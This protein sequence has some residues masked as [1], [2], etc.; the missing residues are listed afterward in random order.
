MALTDAQLADA[1]RYMGYG[2]DSTT[3]L[4]ISGFTDRA[5]LQVGMVTMSLNQLLTTLTPSAE[6]LVISFLA[7]L[8]GLETAITDA[9]TNL[10]TSQAAVW[11]R[12]SN[13]VADRTA[14]FNQKRRSLCQFLEVPYGPGLRSNNTVLRA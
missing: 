4:P 10:G 12:N 9:G 13:E 5:Y 6:S 7:I 1:R 3:T 14:L 11:T 8:N 2:I